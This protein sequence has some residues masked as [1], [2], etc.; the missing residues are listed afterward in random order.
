L[1]SHTQS[2]E[3][4]DEL[5][6]LEPAKLKLSSRKLRLERCQ[7]SV[8]AKAI[9]QKESSSQK[10]D[11]DVKRQKAKRTPSSTTSA[12]VAATSSADAAKFAEELA[13]LPKEQRKAIKANDEKRLA[14]RLAKKK[15]KGEKAKVAI[16]AA[17]AKD[18]IRRRHIK[19]DKKKTR[20]RSFDA[21]MR[22]NQKKQQ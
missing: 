19:P 10:G 4:V 2:P 5:L 17:K 9:K 3:C 12:N 8:K 18:P 6:A 7:S 22:K 20:V 16:E 15:A 14:R 21:E 13:K 11:G 1:W